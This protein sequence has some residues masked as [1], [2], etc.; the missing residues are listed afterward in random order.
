MVTVGQQIGQ[1]LSVSTDPYTE[2][3]AGDDVEKK[4]ITEQIC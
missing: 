3:E 4:L 2:F 1:S